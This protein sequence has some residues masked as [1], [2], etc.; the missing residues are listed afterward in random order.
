VVLTNLFSFSSIYSKQ[1]AAELI[2]PNPFL[3]LDISVREGAE[4]GF[5]DTRTRVS[6]LEKVFE[7]V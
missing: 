1:V 3:L 4:E 2:S 5:I 6:P 7:K